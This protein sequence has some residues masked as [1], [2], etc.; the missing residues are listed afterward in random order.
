MER[1]MISVTNWN[2][3]TLKQ[4]VGKILG[5]NRL[6]YDPEANLACKLSDVKGE[7]GVSVAI[8]LIFISSLAK[9]GFDWSFSSI[10]IWPLA[11][12]FCA[13]VRARQ[14]FFRVWLAPQKLLTMRTK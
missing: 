9:M 8:S 11:F 4:H 13:M 5:L 14:E 7:F 10:V 12:V 6:E 1:E 2:Y 3:Q